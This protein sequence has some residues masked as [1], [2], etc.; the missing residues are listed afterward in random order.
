MTLGPIDGL[1]ASL[2]LQLGVV[3]DLAEG[4][5]ILDSC[6][7]GWSIGEVLRHS[8]AVTQKFTEFA[9]GRSDRPRTPERDLLVPDHRTSAE[10]TIRR[11]QEAWSGA[12]LDRTCHLPFGE[13][14]AEEA[15]GIN[16]FDVLA[17]TSDVAQALDVELSCPDELWEAGRQAAVAVLG[18][19]RDVRH[20]GPEV[21]VPAEA[22]PQTRFLAYLGRAGRA[23]ASE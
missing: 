22:S 5:L 4:D 2:E 12:D 10:R 13:Y 23:Q 15:A 7:P 1:A 9:S 14:R 11:A 21:S 8:L 20:Y 6:C 18:R 19:G 16:L 3:Q 17:H